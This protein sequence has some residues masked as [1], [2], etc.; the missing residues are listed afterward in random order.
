M[1]LDWQGVAD[2]MSVVKLTPLVCLLVPSLIVSSLPKR[3]R[4]LTFGIG[5]GGVVL[6]AGLIAAIL[7]VGWILY[8]GFGVLPSILLF[9]LVGTAGVVIIATSVRPIAFVKPICTRC[10]LL[11]VIKEHES[12]HLVGLAEEGAVW[13]SMRTRHS[14]E[15]LA[16]EGDPKICPFCPIPKRL[17]GN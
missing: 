3:T 1:S 5:R 12:L 4:G 14:V 16:L 9:W 17:K 7:T 10:R 8:P 11:P 15:S 2:R 13:A 6:G